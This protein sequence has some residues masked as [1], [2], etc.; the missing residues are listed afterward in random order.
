MRRNSLYGPGIDV[1]NLSAG[2]K[3]VL[4]EGVEL[5]IRADTVN[6]FNH[7]SFGQPNF[8]LVSGG[9]GSTDANPFFGS[10]TNITSL[11]VGGRTMQLNARISF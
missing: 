1:V 11:T 10:P 7:P 4:H 3:F 6:A 8:G 5:S 9:D 2:K